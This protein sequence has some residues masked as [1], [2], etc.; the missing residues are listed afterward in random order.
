M[1]TDRSLRTASVERMFIILVGEITGLAQPAIWYWP[2]LGK[3]V[4][5]AE[6]ALLRIARRYEEGSASNSEILD[7]A[8]AVRSAWRT[9][10]ESFADRNSPASAQ[11]NGAAAGKM[12]LR[13]PGSAPLAANSSGR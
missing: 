9:A 11:E 12:P 10:V 13:R 3:H 2:E 1:P 4:D 8:E 7:A 5:S 6:R